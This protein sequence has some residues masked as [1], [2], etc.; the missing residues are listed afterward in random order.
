[1]SDEA[2]LA[3]YKDIRAAM[4]DACDRTEADITSFALIAVDADGEVYWG[5][6]YG[7]PEAARKAIIR[8]A[9]VIKSDVQQYEKRLAERVRE[10]L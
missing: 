8:W 10:G 2:Y 9:S 6:N 1:M 3:K 7:G 4:V 5:A